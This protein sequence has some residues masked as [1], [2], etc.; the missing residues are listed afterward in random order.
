MKKTF[1]L[2]SAIL[3]TVIL[4]A[5]TFTG[6]NLTKVAATKD[7]SNVSAT[8]IDVAKLSYDYSQLKDTYSRS[9]M[10]YD[11]SIENAIT[12]YCEKYL[13][14]SDTLLNNADKV[15]PYVTDAYYSELKATKRQQGGSN[16]Q[17]STALHKLYFDNYSTPT[18]YVEVAALCYQTAVYNN[19]S[20]T[21]S[22]FYVFAMEYDNSNNIWLIANVQ[23]PDIS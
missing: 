17:Q 20:E 4:C 15:K 7:E 16:Y 22:T 23:K 6:C 12:T 14:F 19:K 21:Y 8:E 2:L 1:I 9:Q 3:S 13:T 5:M 11:N 18:T 10:I